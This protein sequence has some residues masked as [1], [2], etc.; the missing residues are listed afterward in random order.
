[1]INK[2]VIFDGDCAFCNKSVLFILR[3][4]TK[5]DIF[6]V[7]S[8]SEKGKALIQDKNILHDPKETLIY[9]E[10]NRVFSKSNA[11]LQ[12]SKSL[13]G[14][15]PILYIFKIIPRLLRDLVYD[16]IAKRRKKIVKGN[17]DCSFEMAQKHQQQILG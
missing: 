5:K 9:I 10:K 15:Y 16:F 17:P 2:I 1:M 8:D 14:G 6:V 13:K 4:N 12:I 11:V 7:A 3:K